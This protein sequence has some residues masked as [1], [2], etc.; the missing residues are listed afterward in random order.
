MDTLRLI[1]LVVMA[2]ALL[3]AVWMLLWPAGVKATMD[4]WVKM[5]LSAA[6]SI[7]IVIMAVGLVL[8]GLAI[9]R[10]G[11]PVIAAVTVLGTL[12]VVVGM[13]YQ[14]PN[15]VTT[16]LKPFGTEG[17][18]WA[19]RTAGTVILLVAALLAYICLRSGA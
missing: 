8:I 3:K 10:M 17:K 5:P 19:I 13:F 15:L 16:L 14:W 11:D 4:W 9:V 12:C 7:G 2:G 18:D 1:L 6:R